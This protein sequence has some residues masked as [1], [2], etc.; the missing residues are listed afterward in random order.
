M[1]DG[2]CTHGHHRIE[3]GGRGGGNKYVIAHKQA[4]QA[5]VRKKK[6]AHGIPKWEESGEQ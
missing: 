3:V 2:M 1:V 6:K 5:N 4:K